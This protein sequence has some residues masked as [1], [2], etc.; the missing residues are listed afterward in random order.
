M[1]PPSEDGV[2]RQVSSTPD[3]SMSHACNMTAQ[4]DDHQSSPQLASRGVCSTSAHMCEIYN[5]CFKSKS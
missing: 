2:C 4:F 5:K 3:V 1:T